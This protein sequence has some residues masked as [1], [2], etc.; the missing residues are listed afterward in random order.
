MA[1]SHPEDDV[2]GGEYDVNNQT[3]DPNNEHTFPKDYCTNDVHMHH[4][5]RGREDYE[6]GPT[7]QNDYVTEHVPTADDVNWPLRAA[8]D[9]TGPVQTADDLRGSRQT[10][11]G[12]K[13]VTGSMNVGQNVNVKSKDT[14]HYDQRV[15]NTL[16][17]QYQGPVYFINN[18]Q[19]QTET[20]HE[21]REER[22]DTALPAT[23]RQLEENVSE[24]KDRRRRVIMFL[25]LCLLVLAF[26]AG[27]HFNPFL[28][29]TSR[30]NDTEEEE[31][32]SRHV[33]GVMATSENVKEDQ[34]DVRAQQSSNFQMSGKLETPKEANQVPRWFTEQTQ[35][36]FQWDG[37]GDQCGGG[38]ARLLCAV[39]NTMTP[40][41][42]D[43]THWR[44]GGCQ[45]QWG[46]KAW[47]NPAWF[48]QVQ[49]CFR[50]Y[51]DGDKGQC[52]EGVD[53]E[54]CAP[55]NEYTPFYLDDTDW[56]RGGCQMS[57]RLLVPDTAPEWLKDVRL[58]FQ[59]FP[60]GDAG[61]CGDGAD[62]LLCARANQWT[63]YYRDDTDY[64]SGGC[65]MQW[66]L[67]L[68]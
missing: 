29:S 48:N 22:T 47:G 21:V 13:T 37:D 3:E 38:A 4:E 49:I 45:M 39:P 26:A 44:P 46:I 35:L 68:N 9:V 18:T 30:Q 15:R 55:V 36:C 11:Q 42:L 61:Q 59:W 32:V 2:S 51:P 54:L 41:Y 24:R 5:P 52:G 27:Y 20:R 19:D 56:R 65:K 63:A 62:R 12:V 43:D 17:Q 64:R 40:C 60:G 25:V 8:D 28:T 10:V 1:S 66:G 7:T 34:H 16:V 57:W 53:R 6:N 58:C 23:N 50:W 31:G 67:M 33:S 14:H